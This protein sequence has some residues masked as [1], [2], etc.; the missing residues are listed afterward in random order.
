MNVGQWMR[1][2]SA[3]VAMAAVLA[4][5]A[6][7]PRPA[8]DA[9]L[10]GGATA[11]AYHSELGDFLAGRLAHSAGDTKAAADYYAAALAYDPD[12]LDLLQ[13]A[14]TLMVAEG[15]VDTAMPMAERLVE[16]DSDSPIPQMVLGVR[17]ARAGDF[18]KAEAHFGALPKRGV[19]A[20]LGP[21]LTA[22][23]LVGEGNTDAALKTLAPLAANPALAS[24]R[25]FHSGLMDDLAGRSAAAADQYEAALAAGPLNIRAVEAA[26]SLDQRTG[27]SDLAKTLYDRYTAE[28]P[29]T[30]LFDG[31]ALLRAG[32]KVP[33]AVADA[34]GGL[35]ETMFDVATL[36]RQ[37]NASDYAMLFARLAVALQPDFPLAQMTIADLLSAQGRPAEANAVYGAIAVTSPVHVFGRLRMAMNLDDLGDTA[38]ALAVLDQLAGERP[39]ALDALVTKG[40]VLRKHKRYA[41]AAEAYGLAIARLDGDRPEYWALYYSRGV[42]EERAGRWPA[43]EADLT[44][45][46]QLQPDQPDVLN[47]LGYSWIDKG[48]HLDQARTM[49]ERAVELRPDDGAIVDSLGWALYRMGHF[50]AAVGMLER[51][52]ELKGDDATINEHLG[53]AYWRAGRA[54]EARYQWTRTLDLDPEPGQVEGLKERLRTGGLPADSAAP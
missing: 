50:Q 45:A 42:C 3:V 2:R 5:S 30:M 15:K 11:P 17:D 46:L 40:D 10:S 26:G 1:G 22:W 36:M 33:R 49:I 39:A 51:A 7:G 37:G 9:A 4:V 54:A 41:E 29:E 21:L 14:F 13:R 52:V 20:F 8:G 35:A 32:T 47:Y 18:A 38:G 27:H 48:M 31:A 53:D 34:R 6:C 12:N 28:H 24:L 44:K 16:L 25:A 19:N 43:A 23:A